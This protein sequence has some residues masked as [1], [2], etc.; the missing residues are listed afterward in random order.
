[1]GKMITVGSCEDSN[2]PSYGQDH[3]PIHPATAL[4]ICADCGGNGQMRRENAEKYEETKS[5]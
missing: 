1:M 2:C 5:L 3:G 4:Y